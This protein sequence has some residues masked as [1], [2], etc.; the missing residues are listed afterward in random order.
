MSMTENE[1]INVLQLNKPF[2]ASKEANNA[3]EMA[4]QAL[5]EVQYFK[6]EYNVNWIPCSER[7]PEETGLYVVTH[8]H[9]LKDELSTT[10]FYY[11]S[12]RKVFSLPNERF[13]EVHPIAWQP[14]PQP[15]M[16]R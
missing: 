14:L 4:I 15:Y 7:L 3:I 16:E 13:Y 1:A 8:V 12:V 9:P 10:I 5:E 11:D 6:E 2:T